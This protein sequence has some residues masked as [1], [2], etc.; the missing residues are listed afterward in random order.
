MK[1]KTILL[2][3]LFS[4]LLLLPSL[5]SAQTSSG[6]L[7]VA[8]DLESSISLTFVTDASGVALTGSGTNAATL[9]FGTVSRYGAPA[10]NVTRTSNTTTFTVST[11][12]DVAVTKSNVTSATYALTAQMQ[13]TDGYGWTIDTFVI[14]FNPTAPTALT[15][16]GA[17]DTNVS[18]TL[19]LAIPFTAGAAAISNTINFLATAN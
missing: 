2:A 6:V 11:P 18:H 4:G 1:I 8:A 12:F 14:G 17:Y 5:A 15:A 19:H 3:A 10:A 7:T 16:T 9:D 13:T